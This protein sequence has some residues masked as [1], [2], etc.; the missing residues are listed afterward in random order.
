MN[1]LLYKADYGISNFCGAIAKGRDKMPGA[2]D[3]KAEQLWRRFMQP[4]ES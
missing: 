3:E 4:D 2:I 1:L